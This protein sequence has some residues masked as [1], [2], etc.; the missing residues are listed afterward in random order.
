LAPELN[1]RLAAERYRRGRGLIRAHDR[2][3]VTSSIGALP[4][5][6]VIVDGATR[7]PCLVTGNHLQSFT[8]DGWVQPR[9]R[10]RG[11]NVEI[12]TPATSV[13]ALANGFTPY[14]HSTAV[15]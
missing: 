2:I 1:R 12:L 7:E 10:R 9:D 5:G 3:L 8:F 15:E 4:A 13:A 11:V 6:V 14:L